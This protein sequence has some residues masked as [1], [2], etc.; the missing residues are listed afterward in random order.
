MKKAILLFF[1]M[2]FLSGIAIAQSA[3]PIPFK[4]FITITEKVLDALDELEVVFSN[5]K[6]MKVEVDMAFKKLD[7]ENLKY[8]RYVKDWRKKPGKQAEI[9]KAIA[10]AEIEYRTTAI[11][12]EMK[13]YKGEKEGTGIFGKTHKNAELSTQKARDLFVK[14]KTRGK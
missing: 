10:E 1:A 3:E 5:N 2:T 8:R 11:E 7:T 14:Y 6:S 9:I 12:E 4:E 13:Q